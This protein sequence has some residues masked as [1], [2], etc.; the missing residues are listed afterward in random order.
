MPK[1][2][3]NA[4]Q[5][6]RDRISKRSAISKIRDYVSSNKNEVIVVLFAVLLFL[7]MV[8]IFQLISI[9]PLEKINEISSVAR[10]AAHVFAVLMAG[11]WAAYKVMKVRIFNK[12][13][14]INIDLPN[15]SCGKETAILN[16]KLTNIGNVRVKQPVVNATFYKGKYDSTSDNTDFNPI[17]RDGG[18]LNMY[19]MASDE[20][21]LEPGDE[22]N[23][24][25]CFSLK[26]YINSV[27][28]V[29]IDVTVATHRNYVEYAMFYIDERGYQQ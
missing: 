12:R 13:I 9:Y 7:V 24:N 22:I 19:Y 2:T 20:L 23:I 3:V 4:P 5:F 28:L 1:A 27:L 17:I 11:I 14:K 16:V 6:R 15:D 10:N 18:L 26:E 29:R 21:F 8:I 25:R